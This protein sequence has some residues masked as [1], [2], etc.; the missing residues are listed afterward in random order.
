M[1]KIVT[2]VRLVCL[3]HNVPLTNCGNGRFV[4]LTCNPDPDVDGDG[5]MCFDTSEYYCP[6]CVREDNIDQDWGVEV[7]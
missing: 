2:H 3:T 4:S 5:W 7:K 1:S 6:V